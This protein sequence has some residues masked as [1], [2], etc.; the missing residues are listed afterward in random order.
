MPISGPSPP[1]IQPPAFLPQPAGGLH[2]DL[3]EPH[4]LNVFGSS[5]RLCCLLLQNLKSSTNSAVKSQ[6]FIIDSHQIQGCEC[7]M[8]KAHGSVLCCMLG[9]I[10]HRAGPSTS[11]A[12]LPSH[13]TQPNHFS[14]VTWFQ[15]ISSLVTGSVALLISLH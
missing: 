2:R 7:A 5:L 12:L 9:H 4:Q 11:L 1:A 14:F 3:E 15:F 6:G 10:L 8:G 13:L